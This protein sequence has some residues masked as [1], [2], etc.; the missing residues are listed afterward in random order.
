MI[1]T[2]FSLDRL[3]DEGAVIVDFESTGVRSSDV[4]I[5]YSFLDLQDYI[6]GVTNIVTGY[7]NCIDVRITPASFN[8][9]GISQDFLND[10]PSYDDI[11]NIFL[12]FED[13]PMLA[14]NAYFDKRIWKQT[15][16]RYVGEDDSKLPAWYD[17][18]NYY[19]ARAILNKNI[20][21]LEVEKRH[22]I[23]VAGLPHTSARDVMVV[24]E[25]CKKLCLR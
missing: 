16:M 25:L 21:L 2:K 1:K 11:R 7:I 9:H 24:G 4:F 20:T 19:R 15:S 18:M 22:G 14:Y 6:R 23:T 12:E 17:L 8:I 3:V 10:K 5:S 13:R